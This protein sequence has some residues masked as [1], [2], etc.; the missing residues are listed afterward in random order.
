MSQ[1]L[2]ILFG[3]QKPSCVAVTE[4]IPDSPDLYRGRYSNGRLLWEYLG[5]VEDEHHA[6]QRAVRPG[7]YRLLLD[8][9]VV[10]RFE[11]PRGVAAPA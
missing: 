2:R 3:R 7:Q 11:V 10:A 8:G 9:V 6:R 4:D 1:I 5:V